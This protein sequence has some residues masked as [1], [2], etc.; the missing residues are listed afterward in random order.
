[1]I[2]SYKEGEKDEVLQSNDRHEHSSAGTRRKQTSECD[3][4]YQPYFLMQH[5]N[6]SFLSISCADTGTLISCINVLSLIA[7]PEPQK[8]LT[9]NISHELRVSVRVSVSLSP[10]L[11][12]SLS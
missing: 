10:V 3:F 4:L 6:F 7:Q 8:K 2:S 1:M 9:L 5:A 12:V 11:V